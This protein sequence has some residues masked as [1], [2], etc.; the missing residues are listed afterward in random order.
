MVDKATI[1][2]E[3]IARRRALSKE[4]CSR[5]SRT[6]CERLIARNL[7][8]PIAVYL[9]TPEEIDLTLF[10]ESTL[11]RGVELLAP[12]WTGKTYALAPLKG[13]DAAH[14]RKGPLGILEPLD[15]P[16]TNHLPPTTFLVPGLAFTHDGKR[17]GY[18]GGWY[19]RI[20]SG[21]SAE[22]TKIGLAHAFQ[23]VDDLP[24]EPHD[25]RLTEIMS[26]IG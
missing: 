4:E 26:S 21:V 14:L 8:G 9:A 11:A 20:M 12:R 23:I 15:P 25:I 24:S 18:G 3:M 2:A 22:T 13:F 17:I 19:D 7:S 5:V 10:I 1:R 16:A 6:I